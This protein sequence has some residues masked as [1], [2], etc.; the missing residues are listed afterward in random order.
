MLEKFNY[1]VKR[2]IALNNSLVQNSLA[3]LS[4]KK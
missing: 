1:N 3:F 2:L 4:F